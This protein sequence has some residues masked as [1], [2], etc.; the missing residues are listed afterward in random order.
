M[1]RMVVHVGSVVRASVVHLPLFVV[2]IW[3]PLAHDFLVDLVV[4]YVFLCHE[5][6]L[7]FCIDR[8]RTFSTRYV[9]TRDSSTCGQ[10]PAQL[11]F[12]F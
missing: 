10:V 5:G 12:L 2:P 8:D 7:I 4:R 6:F 3:R 1:C 11:Y 9:A